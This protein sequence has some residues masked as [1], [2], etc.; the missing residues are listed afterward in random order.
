MIR[1][2]AMLLL[3]RGLA[4]LARCLADAF[5]VY[6]SVRQLRAADAPTSTAQDAERAMRLFYARAADAVFMSAPLLLIARRYAI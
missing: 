6:F 4:T 2:R 3:L 1:L 5:V